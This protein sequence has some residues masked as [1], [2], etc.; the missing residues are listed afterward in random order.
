[1]KFE[2]VLPILALGS[3]I[4]PAFSAQVAVA[5]YVYSGSSPSGSYPDSGSELTDSIDVTLAW[6]GATTINASHVGPLV[7]WRFTTPRI[8]FNF[9]NAV[10]IRKVIVWAADSDNAA[11]VG[12][13]THLK[14][15]D[16]NST[17]SQ[18]FAVTNPVGAGWTIPLELSGFFV[19]TNA[20]VVEATPGSE[21]TMLSQVN[22]DDAPEPG[23]TALLA[24]GVLPML[25]RRRRAE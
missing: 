18:T 4:A 15:S 3:L 11:G 5:N 2:Y 14:L 25:L 23:T 24:C 9:A 7:G 19:N 10:T 8:R 1:M 12:L 22:F 21:W 20:L 17:F 16:P 6:G 13:P